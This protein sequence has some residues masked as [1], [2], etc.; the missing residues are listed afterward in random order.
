MLR[1]DEVENDQEHEAA[2]EE[3]PLERPFPTEQLASTNSLSGS[4]HNVF[5]ER[6][7]KTVDRKLCSRKRVEE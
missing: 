5:T 2:R 3:P 6:H 4:R 1:G 7:K